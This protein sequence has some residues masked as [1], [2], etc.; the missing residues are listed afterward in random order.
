MDSFDIKYNDLYY[1]LKK[2]QDIGAAFQYFE[3]TEFNGRTVTVNKKKLLN[4]A[5]CSYMG[6]EKNQKMIKAAIE[7]TKSFGTQTP[8]SR[9]ILSSPLYTEIEKL[10]TKIFPG[11]QVMTQTVTLGHFSVL[12]L[13]IKKDDA[14][15]LD[16]YV[17]NSIRMTSE[18]NKANGTFILL[19]KHNDMN[20]VKYLIK[21]LK[22]D[23]YKKIWYCAD[24]IYSMHGNFINIK[25]LY[26]LLSEE[27]D[28]YAYV[29]D[30]HGSGWYGKNGQGYVLD[31]CG[32]HPKMI[33]AV[34]FAKSFATCGG[35]LITPTK[36]LAELIRFTGQ[37]L[38]FS[39]PI[40][41]GTLGALI[42]SLKIH[43]SKNFSSMQNELQELIKYFRAKSDELNLP[44]VTR[45]LSPIQLLRIGDAE[46]TYNTLA[47]LVRKGCIATAAFYP[48]VQVQDT[49][50]RISLTRHLTKNDIDKF[51]SI[52]KN[53]VDS[54]IY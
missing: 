48:A 35:A 50:I 21:R 24:G 53:I 23:G 26:Q 27:D 51:L 2:L 34:S 25:D 31:T 38:I 16:S 7:A 45:D 41:P 17:H 44:I 18:W 19:S 37:T 15:I 40:Q 39:G 1:S 46:K 5:S 52:L 6:L 33:V 36:E 13:F 10:I 8:S 54:E 32:L 4:F 20:H 14:I 42:A 12:P 9:A 28:F 22:K 49:G 30:A 3:D 29:D 47:N 11:Y 43:L